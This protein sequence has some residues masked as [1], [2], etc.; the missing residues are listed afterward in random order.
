MKEKK[1]EQI[2]KTGPARCS[3]PEITAPA[4]WILHNSMTKMRTVRRRTETRRREKGT[5]FFLQ[6][7]RRERS[8][9]TA[10]A[11]AAMKKKRRTRRTALGSSPT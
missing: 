9:S 6:V 5:H 3:G 2:K 4:V 8:R 1:D 7:N 10:A 11:A